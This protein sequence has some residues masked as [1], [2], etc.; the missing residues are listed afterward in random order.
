MLDNVILFLF[1]FSAVFVTV[2]NLVATNILINIKNTLKTLLLLGTVVPLIEEALF[3]SVLKNYLNGYFC[4]K[5]ANYINAILFGLLHAS[6]YVISK[7]ILI[8]LF[9]VIST[10]YLG[11]YVVQFD[12]FLYAYLTHAIYNT[13][14]VVC[15]YVMYILYCRKMNISYLDSGMDSSCFDNL[16]TVPLSIMYPTKARDDFYINI[17]AKRGPQSCKFFM[18]GSI[19]KE[20]LQRID[21]LYELNKKRK[22]TDYD[23]FDY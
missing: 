22:Y 1:G 14:I 18:R 23:I 5:Y 13:C 11:Y 16:D 6:N 10:T 20:M 7:N 8:T 12:N 3:R 21:K 15:G 17:K 4:V 9:Q 2:Y 19:N